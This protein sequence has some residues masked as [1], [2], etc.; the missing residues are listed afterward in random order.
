MDGDTVQMF[1]WVGSPDEEAQWQSYVDGAKLADEN[2]DVAFSGPAIGSYYTKL[3]TQLRGSSAPCI[4]TMQNGRI[5]RFA[6]ALEPLDEL[7]A[8]AGVDIADYDSS[9]IAQLSDGGSVYALPYDAEPM[10]VYYNKSLFA[11]AGVAEPGTDWTTDDFMAAAKATTTDGVAGFAIGQGLAGVS[12]WLE[13]NGESY[14]SK[15][16]EA[17]LLAPDLIKRFQFIVDLATVDGVA[18]PLEASGGTFPDIDQFSSGQAAMFINGTWDLS[19]QQQELGEE[20]LGVATIPSD[21]GTPRGSIAGTGFAVTES[22]SDK[23]AAFA[24]IAAMTSAESQQ[25]VASS[26]KQVPARADSLDAW[27]GAVGEEAATVV[28]ALTENGQVNP[29]AKNGDK[30]GDLFNQYEVNAFSGSSTVE[31]VLQQVDDGAN[32]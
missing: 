1:T 2:V 15:D 3:T 16:G 14:I 7:A 4:V 32:R 10:V 30:I 23:P 5:D 11:A 9:M 31:E 18:K 19:H 13:A 20:N 29:A 8:D 12:V 6:S 21:D 25:S 22:C 24:A 17:D 26:R 28:A 27:Q